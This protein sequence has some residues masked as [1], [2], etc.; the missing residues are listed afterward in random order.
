M[1]I[2]SLGFAIVLIAL[3]VVGLVA[4]M[5]IST[6]DVIV[7]DLNDVHV[8]LQGHVAEIDAAMHAQELAVTQFAF[9]R[10]EEYLQEYYELD[11][12]VDEAI[13][14]AL[15]TVKK[16]RDLVADG[17]FGK[18]RPLEIIAFALPA[19]V[20]VGRVCNNPETA[21]LERIRIKRFP[22]HRKR[23][24]SRIVFPPRAVP[25][26]LYAHDIEETE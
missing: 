13:D 2:N 6:I 25:L 11:K 8:P 16:D 7:G 9:H 1:N 22:R 12:A 4:V 18:D 20:V 19:G 17:F 14:E 24:R 21:R 10:D 23:Q 3:G 26:P 5:N 15:Q